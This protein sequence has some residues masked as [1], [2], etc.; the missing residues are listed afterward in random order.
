MI[1]HDLKIRCINLDISTER[2][3]SVSEA[4]SAELIRISAIDGMQWSDGT[5]D[6]DGRPNWKIRPA[7][8]PVEFDRYF[9][10]FPT[11]YACNL[12]HL[13]AMRD[14]LS[15][16]EQ[17]TIII[18]DDVEPVG[19]VSAIEV[20]DDCDF[21]YLIGTSHPASR[22]SLWP[23]NQVRSPRTLAAYALLRRA[24][25]LAI[26]AMDRLHVF[27]TAQQIPMRCFESSL[28][29]RWAQP[30]WPE[31]PRIKAYGQR[32]SITQHNKHAAV[33]TFTRDGRKPWIPDCMLPGGV[34]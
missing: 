16:D 17:W 27:Q 30:D 24:A 21:F 7:D 2:W 22:L 1:L 32:E 33:S 25:K 19:D 20:P 9:R 18:E 28:R 12:S 6:K 11:T 4:F 8:A 23:D 31:L 5:Y 15:T 14:F 13:K 29:E 10:M 34:Q 26:D 3:A